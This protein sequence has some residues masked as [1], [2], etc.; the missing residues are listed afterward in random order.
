MASSVTNIKSLLIRSPLAVPD[1]LGIRQRVVAIALQ[2]IWSF[3]S[4][5]ML[6]AAERNLL[7]RLAHFLIL[8]GAPSPAQACNAQRSSTA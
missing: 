8:D 1:S 6:A 3:L 5:A 2:A 4:A 7:F